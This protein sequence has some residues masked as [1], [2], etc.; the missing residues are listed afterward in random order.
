MRIAIF[1][2]QT[3]II[4]LLMPA[5]VIPLYRSAAIDAQKARLLGEIVLVYPLSF[6]FL[7]ALAVALAG[8]VIAFLVWGTY[9]KRST[10]AGQLVPDSGLI[11]V[12]V[13]QPGIVLVKQVVEAIKLID[14]SFAPVC[15][16]AFLKSN[17]IRHPPRS[18]SPPA[19]RRR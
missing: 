17:A 12:Y 5:Q 9:T 4:P 8:V 19:S 10:V 2:I 7:T 3:R 1:I 11:K 18:R 15:S 16:P 14:C 13:Q 6:A